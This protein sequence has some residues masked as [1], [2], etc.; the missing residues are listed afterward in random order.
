MDMTTLVPVMI[1]GIDIFANVL[2]QDSFH[3]EFVHNN[4]KR[5]TGLKI[6]GK[7]DRERAGFKFVLEFE[8]YLI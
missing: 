2:V 7:I 1:N 4:G 3:K 6:D 8:T 5:Y